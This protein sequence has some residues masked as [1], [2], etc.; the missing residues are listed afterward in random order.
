MRRFFSVLASLL[1]LASGAFAAC[2]ATKQNADFSSDVSTNSV[3]LTSHISS[4]GDL[5][6]FSVWCYGASGG[7]TPGTVTLGSQTATQTTVSGVPGPGSPGE[8][9]AFLYYITSAATSGT[10][11]I[12]ANVSGS[13][14]DLQ[15]AYEDFSA[16]AGC[17]F[18]HDQDSPLGK[19]QSSCGGSG[20]GTISQPAIT[21]T[22]A[23]EVLVVFTWTSEHVNN[24]NSP[25]TCPNN[26][27]N[28]ACAYD[29]TKNAM[30][31]VL[32]S[33]SGST[34]N[35]ANDI[36]A[37]DTWQAL[38]TSFSMSGCPSSVPSG[39]TSCYFVAANG[40]DSNTGTDEAHP[41]LHA[42]FMPSCNSGACLTEKNAMNGTAAAGTGIILRGGDTWHFGNSGAS[43]Y[44]GGTWN[45]NV[46]PT[47]NGT[48]TNP[49]YIGVDQNWFSG[50]SWVRPI[51]TGDNPVCNA[52]SLG[53]NC[54]SG[55]YP[56][57]FYYVNT[58]GYQIGSSNNFF[59]LTSRKYFIIDN[60][61]M[62]GLC[63]NITGQQNHTNDYF[64]YGSIQAPVTFTNDYIHGW[65]H[66]QYAGA[67][68]S[69]SCTGSNV[70]FESFAFE[71]SATSTPGEVIR[72]VVVDGSDS[73][74]IGI[75]IC[76]CGFYDVSQSVFRYS[77]QTIVRG[78]STVHD[79]LYEY[80]FENGHSNA[81]ES[82]NDPGNTTIYNNVFRHME[83]TGGTGGVLL[84]MEPPVSSTTYIFNNL[85]YDIGSMEFNNIGQSGSSTG[86]YVY[87]NNTFQTSVSQAIMRCEYLTG[88][89]F[90]DINNHYVTNSGVYISGCTPNTLTTPKTMTNSAATSAG[91]TSAETY[92][93]SP[94]TGGSATVGAGTNK[95]SL[96]TTISGI[97]SAA[98]TA[99]GSDT[100][101]A[102]T[103][104]TSNHTVTCPARTVVARPA[105]AAWDVGT[106]Q[107]N[108][109]TTPVTPTFT[110]ASG[111]SSAPIIV[112]VSTTSGTVICH[113]TTNPPVTNGA[114]TGCTTGTAITTNSGT[115]CVA[116]STVCGD[117]T[118]TTS[119]TQY[120][121]AGLNAQ[122]DSSVASAVYTINPPAVA[123][124]ATIFAGI[125]ILK[126]EVIVP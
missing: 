50:A 64:S 30:A 110:P 56:G 86:S 13:H 51:L 78:I 40:S 107:F 79:N 111:T 73:D 27:T 95:Q 77:S 22:A 16:S 62:T 66:L 85:F 57:G 109:P 38:I 18:S 117:F 17:T 20:T 45:F 104:N 122:S 92:A 1:T 44:A 21:P 124:G 96:C 83:T 10:P 15:V 41:W 33:S 99:C 67:N 97:N 52:S 4:V 80:F 26:I 29:P 91:Y 59:D 61:E 100:T 43:P 71:G 46:S 12:T 74:G 75:G 28:S 101:Y 119:Q 102:C 23:G 70:C 34:A 106:Y 63:Q 24:Y 81:L 89:T 11:T 118:V 6:V 35:N 55:S 19:C 7:C 93:Y 8:G 36:H 42:P 14:T 25:W 114:G 5:V 2:T 105:S 32:S 121:V 47:P 113:G 112:T 88:G 48:S 72:N 84:W 125:A 49:V 103:Y 65:S 94:P 3:T 90:S 9:Q 87:L 53:A 108:G 82:I 37:S 98:G 123:P 120:A 54:F 39:V 60:M 31:Y 116:S 76:Y 126:G 69:G 68:G 115:N 58:C